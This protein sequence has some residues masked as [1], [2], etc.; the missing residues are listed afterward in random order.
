MLLRDQGLVVLCI[1]LF[2][3]ALG[4]SSV[5]DESKH[6]LPVGDEAPCCS[7]AGNS[8]AQLFLED[9]ALSSRLTG[10]IAAFSLVSLYSIGGGVGK[11]WL[12][13]M[14]DLLCV[15]GMLL[16]AV[17]VAASGLAVLLIPFSR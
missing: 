5:L 14:V 11:L 17:T 12:G 9:L 8:P 10:G 15:N 4:Q 7:P 1:C 2:L 16:Y 13:I 6:M 3:Y